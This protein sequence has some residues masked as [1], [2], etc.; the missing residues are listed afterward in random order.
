MVSS[1]NLGW[2]LNSDSF[3][4]YF[5]PQFYSFFTKAMAVLEIQFRIDVRYWDFMLAYPRHRARVGERKE[6]KMQNDV[7]SLEVQA[8]V[9]NVDVE[10]LEARLE[11]VGITQDGCPKPTLWGGPVYC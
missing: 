6:K 4:Q 9:E 7:E 5:L 2:D 1:R 10:E 3:P 11:M 8:L